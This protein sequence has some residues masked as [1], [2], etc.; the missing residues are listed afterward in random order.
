LSES[1]T[2][3]THKYKHYDVISTL[4]INIFVVLCLFENR[5]SHVITHV[6]IPLYLMLK[7]VWYYSV[8]VLMIKNRQQ[9]QCFA[10]VIS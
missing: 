1:Q 10:D 3:A 7:H 8:Q 6:Y 9:L 2:D 4:H 5:V